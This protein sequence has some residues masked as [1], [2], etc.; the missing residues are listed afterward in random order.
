MR[1]LSLLHCASLVPAVLMLGAGSVAAAQEDHAHMEQGAD[2]SAA[3]VSKARWSDPAAWPDGKVP[4]AGDAVTIPRNMEVV[5]DVDPPALR[6]LT[7]DG[8]LSFSNDLDIELETEWIYVRGGELEIGTEASPHTR[9][10]VITLT[11]NIRD[12]DVNT[13]GDRGI[14]LMRGT[15]NLHGDREHT[16]TKLAKTAE[17]GSAEIE[18]LDASGWRKGDEIVLASTDFNPRQAEKRRIMAIRG[19]LITLDRKLDYMHFGQITQGVDQRGEVGLLTRNIRVQASE[20]AEETYFGGHIMAMPGSQ[21]RA[22]GVE[23]YR[24]GQNMHLARYPMHWH[25]VGEGA[26]QYIRN[27]AIHNTYSRCVTVHGTNNV[28][29]ENNVTFDTVGHCFFLEDAVE[30]GNQFVRNLGIMTKCHPTLPCEPTNLAPGGGS[31]MAGQRAKHVLIPS[32][33]TAS[34]FWITN[35]DNIYRDNVAAGSDQIGFWFALPEHPTGQFEG[36]ETS[37]NTWPRRIPVREFKGNTAHSNFDGL[38]FDRG[39]K[40]DGTFSVVGSNYHTGHA[41]PSDPDSQKLDSLFEDFTGYKNR[42]GAIWARGE[43]HTFKNLKLADNAIGFTHA[44]GRGPNAYSSRVID[45]IFVGESDNIGNPSSP[46]EIAYGRSLPSEHADFPIRGYEYY[47]MRHDVENVTFVNFQPNETR[48]AGAIS[49]LMYTSFGMSTEN[50]V[51]GATFVDAK[52]VSFPPVVRRWASDFGRGNA[53]RGAAIHDRDGS[54]GGVPDSYIVLDNGIASD[55]D[56]CDIRPDWGAAICRGDFGH[57]GLGGNMGFGSGPIADPIMLSRNG[58]RW[59]YTGQT[60]IRSGA[61]VRVETGR[62]NLSLSLAEMDK[63]SWVIFELPGFTT[64][65]EGEQLDSLDALRAA[66]GTA[67]YKDD[68]T[69]WVKLVAANAGGPR[70]PGRGPGAGLEVRR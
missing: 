55:E 18:V 12:E 57:F 66:Q 5:L 35:P 13:M 10:A 4:G 49:Y 17:A 47:D 59:E 42:N 37:A 45:S 41:D 54:V 20:D 2:R 65:A 25:L 56:A 70:G 62:D 26:G 30:T 16:W 69:L 63:G 46:E 52:P 21:V 22:S 39:P 1:K 6:S 50:A 14:L 8:K 32:D 48:D 3:A 67:Y 19:N 36:T 44:A 31:G 15:L 24:M 51:E 7:I 53:W 40:P 43:L 23:L 61:E 38:M 9:K 27:A 58:R 11:D 34:T 68:S 29:V 60:T 33:N 64:A 28:R